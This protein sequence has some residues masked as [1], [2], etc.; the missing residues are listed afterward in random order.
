[1]HQQQPVFK[2]F[3]LCQLIPHRKVTLTLMVPIE[4]A[5]QRLIRVFANDILLEGSFWR[6]TRHYWGHIHNNQIVLHGPQAHRQ[7]CFRTQGLLE[8]HEGQI[9][10]RLLIQLSR[11]DLYG[12]LFAIVFL[13]IALPTV[14][15]GWGVQLMPFYFGFLYVMVQWHFQ[16][17]AHEISILLANI[18]NGVSLNS[19]LGS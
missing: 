10:L 15:Q 11:R 1:M 9:I 17:Y 4:E 12:L 5:R 2:Q 3:F 6:L 7:F 19:N 18:I 16:H 8:K 13:A 14:L